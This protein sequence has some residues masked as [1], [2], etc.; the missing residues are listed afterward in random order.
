M[1]CYFFRLFEKVG[2][3]CQ[4][5]F[6]LWILLFELFGKGVDF[7]RKFVVFVLGGGGLKTVG[8]GFAVGRKKVGSWIILFYLS[9]FLLFLWVIDFEV[10][11]L[12]KFTGNVGFGVLWNFV[13]LDLVLF[14]GRCRGELIGLSL[15]CSCMII[16]IMLGRVL[17]YFLDKAF[18]GGWGQEFLEIRK[19]FGH[20]LKIVVTLEK[21]S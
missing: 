6:K 12:G 3:F 21:S 10:L 13:L 19:C 11:G 15:F 9:F 5:Y 8:W 18:L 20:F 7:R 16:E 1:G 4:N 2:R 17:S 14:G